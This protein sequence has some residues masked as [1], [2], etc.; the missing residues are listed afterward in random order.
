MNPANVLACLKQLMPHWNAADIHSLDY[1]TGGYSNANYAL[2]YDRQRF[3]LRIPQRP[4]PYVDRRRERAWY[5]RLPT[6][7]GPKPIALDPET[8]VMLSPWAEGTLLIDA[9]PSLNLSDLI[10]YLRRLHET[11]PAESRTYDVSELMMEYGVADHQTVA[12]AAPEKQF[13]TCHNDL[14]PWNILVT[15]QGWVTLDWEFVG[16]NDPLFDLVSLHQGLGLSSANLLEFASMY[17][18]AEDCQT[19]LPAATKAYW[20]REYGWAWYQIHNGNQRPEISAQMAL[21]EDALSLL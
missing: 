16:L 14:N 2:T 6:E 7:I 8:G 3:V 5:Q 19:R 11:L 12:T 21:A 15:D 13:V 10:N 18:P 4:Q 9:W 1:L 20:L 17:L